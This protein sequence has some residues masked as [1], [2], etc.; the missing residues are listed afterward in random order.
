MSQLK[1]Q[2]LKD[3]EIAI[4]NMINNNTKNDRV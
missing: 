2:I 4:R 3:A 1:Q